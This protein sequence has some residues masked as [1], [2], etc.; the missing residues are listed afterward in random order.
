MRSCKSSFCIRF[1][2]NLESSSTEQTFSG[3]IFWCLSERTA[4]LSEE[5]VELV[6]NIHEGAQKDFDNAHGDPCLYSGRLVKRRLFQRRVRPI[7]ER[8]L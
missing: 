4:V 1:L 2:Q 7:Y 3:G 6:L 8:Q 5:V